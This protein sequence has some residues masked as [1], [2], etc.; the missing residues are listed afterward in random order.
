MVFKTLE[1]HPDDI[2][3]HNTEPLPDIIF[4]CVDK[5]KLLELCELFPQTA[6][7]LKRKA[8]EKRKRFMTQKNTMS[9]RYLEK[10]RQ[11]QEENQGNLY[12]EG[13]DDFHTDEE[14]EQAENQNEDMKQYLSKLN[15]RIDTL[16]DALK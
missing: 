14:A 12:D 7:N 13:L 11:F 4:M 16:V 15:K 8:L 5:T 2:L 1:R 6:E 3:K 9:K 10:A